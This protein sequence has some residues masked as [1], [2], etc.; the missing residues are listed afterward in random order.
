MWIRVRQELLGYGLGILLRIAGDALP[1]FQDAWSLVYAGLTTPPK[2][3]SQ[4]DSVSMA[5]PPHPGVARRESFPTTN[6]ICGRFIHGSLAFLAS[7]SGNR[8]AWPSCESVSS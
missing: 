1:H 5:V 2:P 7:P 4:G 6:W 3:D 8:R